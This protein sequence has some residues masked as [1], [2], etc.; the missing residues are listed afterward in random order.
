MI[1]KYLHSYWA[2]F[3]L[4]ILLIA[5]LNAFRGWLKNSSFKSIDLRI[6]LFGLIFSHIQLLLG[7]IIYFVSPYFNSWNSGI[8]EIMQNSTLRLYL[9]EHPFINIIAIV[10]ITLGWSLHKKQKTD[11]KKFFR[12]MLFY[13]IGLVLIFSRIPW[14]N[15]FK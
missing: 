4:I 14:T 13:L 8:K 5:I 12:I 9:I 1:I 10:F 2:L 15:W 11:R 7:I 6:S 3:T